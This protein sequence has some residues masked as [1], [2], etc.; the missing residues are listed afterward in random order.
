MR[1][2]HART[3]ADPPR[4]RVPTAA[5]CVEPVDAC[6]GPVAFGR[7]SGGFARCRMRAISRMLGTR[8]QCKLDPD[9]PE[10]AFIA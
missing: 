7:L 5:V 1:A 9:Q 2:S 4:R 8:H 6:G 10:R 3:I